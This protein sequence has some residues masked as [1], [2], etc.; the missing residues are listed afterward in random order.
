MFY[1]KKKSQNYNL[2]IKIKKLFTLTKNLLLS[3]DLLHIPT[4]V[5][6]IILVHKYKNKTQ[7]FVR[8]HIIISFN[9]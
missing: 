1:S 5:I 9:I 7:Y 8:H 4:E 3:R 2:Q 6:G